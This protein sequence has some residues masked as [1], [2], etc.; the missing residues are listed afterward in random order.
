MLVLEVGRDP[1]VLFH[2]CCGTCHLPLRLPF[3]LGCPKGFPEAPSTVSGPKVFL[4]PA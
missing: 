4:P 3:P 2:F 1:D